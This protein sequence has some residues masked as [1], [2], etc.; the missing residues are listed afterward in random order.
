MADR[1]VRELNRSLVEAGRT[2]W[3]RLEP[4]INP[5]LFP[6][7]FSSCP[8]SQRATSSCHRPSSPSLSSSPA[9]LLQPL[10]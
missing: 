10:A 5:L 3:P 6:S 9:H 8:I 1:C 2:A 4:Y 7:P